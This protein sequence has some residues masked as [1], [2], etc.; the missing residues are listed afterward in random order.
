MD[1]DS[2]LLTIISSFTTS[3]LTAGITY[4]GM[5]KKSKSDEF[6][7]LVEAQRK[8]QED[9][10]SDLQIAK[11]ETAAYKLQIISFEGQIMEL[12]K[13]NSALEIKIINYETQLKDLKDTN[14][15]LES[16]I[17]EYQTE[18]S[19]LRTEIS[20]LTKELKTY[21]DAQTFLNTH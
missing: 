8:F 19:H 12:R 21:R 10:R 5:K 1:I 13:T 20:S 2:S 11:S 4:L 9:I 3:A 6:T 7:T 17:N 16:K 18:I 15:S 14:I